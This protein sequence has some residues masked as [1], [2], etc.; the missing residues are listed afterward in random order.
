MKAR[1]G[2]HPLTSFRRGL[3]SDAGP[4]QMLGQT[5]AHRGTEYTETEHPV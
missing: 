5:A 4:E 1:L 2:R 3:V